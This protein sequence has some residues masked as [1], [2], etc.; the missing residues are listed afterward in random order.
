MQRLH[1]LSVRIPQAA[2]TC[3]SPA[4]CFVKAVPAHPAPRILCAVLVHPVNTHSALS[5]PCAHPP[6]PSP[7]LTL[8]LLLQPARLGLA[9]CPRTRSLNHP[10]LLHLCHTLPLGSAAPLPSLPA[11]VT[12]V[13]RS[14]MLCA[15]ACSRRA[16]ASGRRASLELKRLMEAREVRPAGNGVPRV[17][18]REDHVCQGSMGVRGLHASDLMHCTVHAAGCRAGS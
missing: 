4:P 18:C 15:R 8:P 13:A 6:A 12:H 14:P 16:A 3:M 9:G 2:H 5:P 7:Y 11:L 1:A 17:S 10:L